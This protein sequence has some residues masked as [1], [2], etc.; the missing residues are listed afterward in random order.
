M[1]KHSVVFIDLKDVIVLSILG[2]ALVAV[3]VTFVIVFVQNKLKERKKREE[4]SDSI[5]V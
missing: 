5:D 4:S 3:I 2:A 1:F